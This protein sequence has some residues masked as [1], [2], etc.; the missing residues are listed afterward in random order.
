MW[1]FGCCILDVSYSV[2]EI[3]VREDSLLSFVRHFGEDGG[4]VA[5]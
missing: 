1:F 4:A 2:I 3:P 5:E